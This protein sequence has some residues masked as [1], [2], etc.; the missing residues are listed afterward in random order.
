M[1][2]SAAKR[3]TAR[4]LHNQLKTLAP[5][6]VPPLILFEEAR[7]ATG[8]PVPG[9]PPA[10]P[11]EAAPH[12]PHNQPVFVAIPV[13]AVGAMPPPPQGGGQVP[14]DAPPAEQGGPPAVAGNHAAACGS[15]RWW[16]KF[17]VRVCI[18]VVIA[19]VLRWVLATVAG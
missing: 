19:I 11:L 18:F 6:L 17:C 1:C 9:G 14:A 7:R 3:P 16:R 4:N 10:D 5:L 15:P 12:Q 13:A 8:L 2:D